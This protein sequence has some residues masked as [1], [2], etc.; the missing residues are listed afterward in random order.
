MSN[1]KIA[2][3]LQ[4]MVLGGVEKELITVLNQIQGDYDV[5]VLLLYAEDMEIL[6]EIPAGVKTRILGIDKGYYCGSAADL[7]KQRIKKG[8]C[9]EAVTIGVKR[10][11]GIGMSHANTNIAEIPTM[12]EHFD[13]AICYHIHSP[14]MLKYVANS[15]Q[16]NKKVAWIHSDFYSSGYPIQ[17][18]KKYVNQYDEF[19]AVSKKVEKEFRE[20]CPWYQSNICTAYNYLDAEMILKLAKEP[21]Q[22]YVFSQEDRVKLLT[23]GRFSNEK[24]IDLAIKT[25]AMLKKEK[26][27]F[28]WFLIGYGELENFYRELITEYDVADC[29][30]ILGRKSNPYPYIK[31]C[32]VYVQPSRHEAFGLVITEAKILGKTIVCSDFDGADEQIDHGVNGIIVPVNDVD[33]LTQELSQLIRSPEK[34][35]ALSRELDGWSQEDTLREIVKHFA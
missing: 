34:R 14:L 15:I 23:V 35:E 27:Q 32:D 7:V 19:I 6:K 16:A 33:A 13:T 2:F 8:K 1:K 20:L 21:S 4:T 24:G 22:E 5:T 12:D 18:L 31:N 17:K 11:L 26:L 25:A 29:F 9:F 3:C 30:T 28:H 10:V